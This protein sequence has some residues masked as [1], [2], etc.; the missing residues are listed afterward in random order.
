MRR[1][2]STTLT[3]TLFPI[4]SVLVGLLGSLVLIMGAVTA[5]ALGPARTVRVAISTPTES[6]DRTPAYIEYDGTGFTLHPSLDR[7][8]FDLTRTVLTDREIWNVV[9]GPGKLWDKY[10]RAVDAKFLAQ[11]EGTALAPRLR[12]DADGRPPYVV[13]LVRPSG[14]DS[15]IPVRNFLLRQKVDVGYEPIE[16][17]YKVRVR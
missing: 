4:L 14:F 1:R 8:P 2:S 10:W 6:R 5:F 11:I 3:P 7:V 17:T 13:V 9:R 12:K 16:Q 15:F